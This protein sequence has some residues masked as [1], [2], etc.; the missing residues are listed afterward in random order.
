MTSKLV[1]LPSTKMQPQRRSSALP[2][3]IEKPCCYEKVDEC[4]PHFHSHRGR[5][6]HETWSSDAARRI[7]MSR[8][9][10]A[11]PKNGGTRGFYA[12]SRKKDV[13][14]RWRRKWRAR[15]LKS[16]YRA[17][18]TKSWACRCLPKRLR[19]KHRIAA[20]FHVPTYDTWGKVPRWYLGAFTIYLKKP[21]L[22]PQTRRATLLLG[23][24]CCAMR[25]GNVVRKT[26][27]T[28]KIAKLVNPLR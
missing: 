21:R 22:S 23:T 17:L 5:Q 24:R 12:S 18:S 16:F 13:M 1:H 11:G 8:E 20:G 4:G 10:T 6:G 14:E 7:R 28:C 3:P 27:P 19:V 9:N 26:R 2:E 15:R 25:F